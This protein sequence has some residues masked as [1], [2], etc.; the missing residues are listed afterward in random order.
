MEKFGKHCSYAYVYIYQSNLRAT[1][2]NT[3]VEH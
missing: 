3:L 1:C 2:E